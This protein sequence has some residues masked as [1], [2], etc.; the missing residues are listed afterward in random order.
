M[1]QTDTHIFTN[2]LNNTYLINNHIQHPTSQHHHPNKFLIAAIIHQIYWTPHLIH[3]HRVWAHT[4][5]MGN[6]IADTL[7]NEGTLKKKPSA[8]PHINLAHAMP[9]WLASS[10]TA[11][12]A[13]G[14]QCVKK[15]RI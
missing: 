11:T 8:T 10:P 3:I 2:S 13:R 6:E 15:L 4:C 7:A 12:H 1:P 14:G 9:Y 5:I